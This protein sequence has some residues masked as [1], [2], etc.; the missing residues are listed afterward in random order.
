MSGMT[1]LDEALK[2]YLTRMKRTRSKVASTSGL[3]M[4]LKI[5]LKRT[6]Q[7]KKVQGHEK[8]TPKSAEWSAA[9]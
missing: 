6:F 4:N 9:A 1:E 3:R 2:I 8:M 7:K 5:S